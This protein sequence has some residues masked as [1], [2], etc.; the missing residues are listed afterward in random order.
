MPKK[1]VG[2]NRN[3]GSLGTCT[4]ARDGE[5]SE[6]EFERALDEYNALQGGTAM[7]YR[8]RNLKSIG[9]THLNRGPSVFDDGRH[10]R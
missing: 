10:N 6:A 5:D 2:L 1:I 9:L 4:G 3:Q 8:K 7:E